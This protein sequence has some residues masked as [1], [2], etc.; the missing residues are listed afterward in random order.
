M[1]IFLI[2][3]FDL[4][5]FMKIKILDPCEKDWLYIILDPKINQ[6][7]I[8]KKNAMLDNNKSTL[9]INLD[10]GKKRGLMF[11]RGFYNKNGELSKYKVNDLVDWHDSKTQGIRIEYSSLGIN[12]FADPK[13][14]IQ[15]ALKQ[16]KKHILNFLNREYKNTIKDIKI[17]PKG[18]NDFE[19]ILKF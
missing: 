11:I 3:K 14:K 9:F 15:K 8:S 4:S 6:Y 16:Y 17:N 5:N 13:I 1:P 19:L 12:E 10:I 2:K 7:R 18:I